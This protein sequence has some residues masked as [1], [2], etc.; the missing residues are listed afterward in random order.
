MQVYAPKKRDAVKRDMDFIREILMR[1]EDDPQFNG[2]KF[3]VFDTSDFPNHSQDEIA[4][5]IDLLFEA[6]LVTG[7]GTLDA[8]APAISRLTWSGHE[9][10]ADTRDT[11]IWAAVKERIKGLPDVGL[12]IIWE[13]AKAELKKKTGLDK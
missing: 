3:V 12:A 9:F 13:L 10:V 2:S 6:D 4:Y 5:H 1:V 8:P 7:I 11:G